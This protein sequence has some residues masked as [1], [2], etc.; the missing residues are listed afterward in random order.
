MR[1]MLTGKKAIKRFMDKVLKTQHCWIWNGAHQK[2]GYGRFFIRTLG[3]K[4]I[5]RG[6]HRVSYELFKGEIPKGYQIDHLC[7]NTRCVNPDHLEAVTPRVNVLRS[8]NITAI[9]SRKTH[10]LRDHLL[11]SINTHIKNGHR[12][13]RTCDRERV[14]NNR[15][16]KAYQA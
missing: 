12:K 13:C 4:N 15:K 6:S 10:C 1:Y 9:Q 7:R 16:Q 3:G 5:L 14:S 2:E 8:N 11:D